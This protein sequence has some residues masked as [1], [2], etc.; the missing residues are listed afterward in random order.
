MKFPPIVSAA[1]LSAALFFSVAKAPAQSPPPNANNDK[2][3]DSLQMVIDY[4][5]GQQ[6]RRQSHHWVM[7]PV[8][9]ATGQ[10]VTIT[11]EFSPQ[12]A[13]DSVVIGALD[14]GR[15]DPQGPVVIP[16]NG[17]LGF[18]FQPGRTPG[19]YRLLV[20]GAEQYELSLYAFDPNR[21]TKKPHGN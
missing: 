9:L 2:K 16:A 13:G 5:K 8:G 6:N 11:L 15:I 1:A 18:T 7:E 12:R 21:P 3:G 10:P 14:G 17:K 4:G 20:Q 19:L